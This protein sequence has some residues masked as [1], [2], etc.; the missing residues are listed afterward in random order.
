[1]YRC[2]IVLLLPLFLPP[3]RVCNPAMEKNSFWKVSKTELPA[4]DSIGLIN[5][6]KLEAA[7]RRLNDRSQGA[8]ASRA[9]GQPPPRSR[10][11]Q[12][13]G[14]FANPAPSLCLHGT[15]TGRS[16]GST[17]GAAAPVDRWQRWRTT[18]Q[19]D[20]IAGYPTREEKARAAQNSLGADL[21]TRAVEAARCQ[22][23]AGQPASHASGR[24]VTV[25]CA[26]FPYAVAL[27]VPILECT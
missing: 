19:A 11:P 10:H 3:Q 4:R 25:T 1:L 15:T 27:N 13:S 9:G 22:C 23:G 6:H 5:E 12:R 24:H 14:L 2:A 18:L 17:R 8:P 21:C 7:T 16:G 20:F 26:S